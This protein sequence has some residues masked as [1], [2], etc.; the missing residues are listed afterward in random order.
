VI[1]APGNALACPSVFV[2][3]GSV[4]ELTVSESGGAVIGAAWI[5]NTGR[6]RD[7]GRV[8]DGPA[9]APE[10]VPDSVNV[11]VPP[12]GRVTLALMLPAPDAGQVPPA[13]PTHVRSRP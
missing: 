5:G 11:A 2:I 9:A 4:F 12:E 3:H 13:A 6:R 10:T 1:C 8:A 7:A